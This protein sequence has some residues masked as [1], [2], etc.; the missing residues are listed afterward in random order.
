M[1]RHGNHL[2]GLPRARKAVRRRKAPVLPAKA[3][4]K[5]RAA[6]KRRKVP[7]LGKR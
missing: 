5:A 6:V 2:T 4:A 1:A 7:R 3:S